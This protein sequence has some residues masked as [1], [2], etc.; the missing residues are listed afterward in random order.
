M[1]EWS[2][3]NS[4]F[5]KHS[6]I[7]HQIDSFN[8][9]VRFGLQRVINEF[10]DLEIMTKNKEECKIIFGEVSI[11]PVT[12]TEADGEIKSLLP[13]ECSLRNLSYQ[14]NMYINISIESKNNIQHYPKVFIGRLPIMVKSD[15]CNLMHTENKTECT[16]DLGGYFIISGCEKVLI[17]QEKMNNNQVYIF[18]KK[19][20]KIEYEAEIRSLEE[21]DVKST[22]TLKVTLNKCSEYDY[23]LQLHLP[24]LKSEIPF[25]LI[26]TMFNVDSNEFIK[27]YDSE[28][29]NNII[30]NSKQNAENELFDTNITDYISK[31]LN[32][33]QKTDIESIYDKYILPHMQTHR[34]KI[35]TF[36]HIIDK[37]FNVFL[38]NQ[39]Q[40][41]RDHYKN[42]RVELPGELLCSLFRQLFKK[43]HKEVFNVASKSFENNGIINI[44]S[45][46]KHKIITNGIKYALA[47]G[48]WG[49]GTSQNIRTGVSQVLNRHSYLSTLS[50]LRRINSPIG[51]DGKITAPRQL[52]GSHAYRICPCETP[53]G[54]SC[55][56]VKN[57]ALTTII[58]QGISSTYIK[59]KL[60]NLGVIDLET[61][62]ISNFCK[63]FVNGFWLGY[64]KNHNI[65]LNDLKNLKINCKISPDTGIAYDKINN[66]IRINTDAGR[67]CRPVFVLNKDTGNSIQE[68][69]KHDWNTLVTKG[70]V[71]LIDPDEEEC[72]LIAFSQDDLDKR[73]NLPFTH[74][75]LHPS[76]MLG[77]CAS[78]IPYANHNQAPRNVYQCLHPNTLV[79][80]SDYSLKPIKDISIGEKVITFNNITLDYTSSQVIDQFTKETEKQMFHI[81]LNSSQS[82]IATFD[83]VFMT[84]KGWIKVNDF[85][86]NTKLS[87]SCLPSNTHQ[88][89][90]NNLIDF[91]DL[92]DIFD[93]KHE[94]YNKKINTM[95]L[96]YPLLAKLIGFVL[97]DG[98]LNVYSK[99]G[100]QVQFSC[101]SFSSATNLIQDIDS[102]GFGTRKIN[103]GTRIV[104][105]AS[106]HT[107]DVTYCGVFPYLLLLLDTMYGKKTTQPFKL[108]KWIVQSNSKEIQ[109][110]FLSGLF[111]G[112]GSKI[113]Y[114][115]MKS[116]RV[117]YTLNTF[118]KST[119]EEYVDDLENAMKSI[120]TMLNKLGVET[121][122]IRKTN[123][124]YDKISVH[125]GMKQTQDNIIHFYD[126][127][128]YSYDHLKSTDSGK[129]VMFLKYL[130]SLPSKFI[131]QYKVV[132][133][134][135]DAIEAKGNNLL[136]GIK[137]IKKYIDSNIISD[138]SVE[139]ENHSFI[140]NGFL[141]HNS[142]MGKQAMGQYATNHQIRFDSYGHVLWYPQKPLVKTQTNDIF[143]FDNMPGGINC[144]VAIACYG[145]Y[146]QED[147]LIMS[148]SA[149]DRGLFR[150]FFYRV[151]KDE[152]KHHGANLKDVIE[153]PKQSECAG[154]RYAQYKKLD[155]DGLVA[156]GQHLNGDDIVIGKTSTIS[157]NDISGKSKKD[158]STIMRH[159]ESGMV[160]S[161]LV[162][163][164]EQGQ[165]LVKAKVRSMR[166]PEIGDKFSSRHGQ[167]GTIGITLTQ[168]DMP[169]TEQGIIP[170]I[171]VNPHAIPSR[172]T[173]AQLIECIAGKTATIQG[174]RKNATCFD[175]ETP[176]E[177][178]NQLKALGYNSHGTETMYCG[179][180]GKA[181]KAKIFIGPTY[182]QRLKHMVADKQHA[183]SKGPIQILT[184]QPVEGRARDGGL[185]LTSQPQ[186]DLII[187]L[188]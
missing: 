128:G 158:Y 93:V 24:F 16:H 124:K 25:F 130:R 146:N 109:R 68:H 10:G 140:A 181:L 66:E 9:F 147:S 75:E 151:Y 13:H 5:N 77:I 106:H 142:A 21:H 11:S 51:K 26:F 96:N 175:H 179:Y 164:N 8:S 131:K 108:P 101:S 20:N 23:N 185:R 138:I 73:S 74:C 183:R 15:Y 180:T 43:M 7:Q 55:G 40:D 12:H 169:F 135:I 81:T 48:N 150:S 153:K 28:L 71:E 49:I 155:E 41:D 186:W 161:V 38:G 97:T 29:I 50:H 2:V 100:P 132:K 127:I 182:Y 34:R 62:T 162:S 144:V 70:L 126:T 78:M 64:H 114:N 133:P 107:F 19:S 35:F 3:I 152:S 125:L 36:G 184:R 31:R 115:I 102:M 188:V 83:H 171:I 59:S 104:H 17:S 94:L 174:D 37:M 92:K 110:S 113:R 95:T 80:M 46:I 1:T 4:Y 86:S 90:Q 76:L 27:N 18:E 79:T 160:D 6:L 165:N 172:M 61:T 39:P 177:I 56:L 118:S 53:E 111:G 159:N 88:E 98:A 105:G 45:T 156:P 52:H 103:E 141:V 137:S 167:K 163:S 54:A 168:E 60:L 145:G 69:I 166:V 176:E 148:Q 63:I 33:Y 30:F 154:I 136:I 67:C 72:A 117:N 112:D 32:V 84:D 22:S 65:L 87:Y 178:E 99:S 139:S 149:V 14:S 82:I 42:K 58:S 134:F 123:G 120:Q 121:N 129:V 173:V 47:T 157:Q 91:V 44:Q 170:D 57:M 122:Y 116:N 89:N 119:I 143:D 85:N 187:L